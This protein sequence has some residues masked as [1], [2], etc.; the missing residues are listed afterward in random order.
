MKAKDIREKAE[1]DWEK[2]EA[3]LRQDL[4]MTR[5][6]LHAG[7]LANTAKVGALKRDLARILTIR[8]A[9]E[10]KAAEKAPAKI[11]GKAQ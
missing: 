1:A 2:M 5:L 6:Q 11:K 4:A 7:Q 8:K 9:S 10:S 3:S